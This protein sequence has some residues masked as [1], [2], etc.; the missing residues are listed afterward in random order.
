MQ[1][2][3]K[4]NKYIEIVTIPKKIESDRKRKNVGIEFDEKIIL[5]ILFPKR[6][7]V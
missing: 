1:N 6:L 5:D 4:I 3:E 7:F 2:T